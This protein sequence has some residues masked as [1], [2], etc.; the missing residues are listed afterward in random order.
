MP[1]YLLK[2]RVIWQPAEG[3]ASARIRA[4]FAQRAVAIVGRPI[5]RWATWV[6]RLTLSA[7]DG[8][9]LRTHNRLLG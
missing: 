5:A 8:L 4:K 7:V 9:G 6:E 1:V 3:S 2:G